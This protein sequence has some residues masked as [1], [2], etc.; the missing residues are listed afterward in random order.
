[1][2]Y[3]APSFGETFDDA[4]CCPRWCEEQ[5][6]IQHR[7]FLRL[8]DGSGMARSHYQTIGDGTV[9]VVADDVIPGAGPPC[10]TQPRLIIAWD[11][12]AGRIDSSQAQEI[13]ARILEGAAALD[14]IA[15]ESPTR[16]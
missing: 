5:D 8:A 16:G 12:L 6:E 11:L 1:M 10:R 9:M 4:L 14:R 3:G 13:A 7:R 15:G 2:S